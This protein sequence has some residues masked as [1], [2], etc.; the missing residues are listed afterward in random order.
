MKN[1]DPP[2]C[3]LLVFGQSTEP[4]GQLVLLIAHGI[5]QSQHLRLVTAITALAAQ[6]KSKAEPHGQ[7]DTKREN[8]E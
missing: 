7:A 4:A 2:V 8:N 3:A 1:C 5:Y 6:H